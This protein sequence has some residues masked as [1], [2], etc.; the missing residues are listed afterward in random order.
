MAETEKPSFEESLKTLEK[1][2]EEMESGELS[3]DEMVKRF[4]EGRKLVA[5]CTT[6]LDAIRQRIEKVVS[7]GTPG[8]APV[9]EP[10]TL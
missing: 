10:L 8:T 6:E 4:E 7:A 5:S 3:L 9:V 2:V 1:L